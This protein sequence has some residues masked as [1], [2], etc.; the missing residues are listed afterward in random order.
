M[1][2]LISADK[3]LALT[4]DIPEWK[5]A[6]WDDYLVYRDGPSEEKVKLFFNR[7]YLF[8]EMGGEGITHASISRLFAMLFFI[9]FTRFPDKI[10]SDLGGCLLEKPEKQ[11]A[12]PDIVLYIGENIPHWKEGEPRRIDL[13]KWRVPDLVGEVADTTLASDLD[14]KKRLYADLEIPEYWV[15]DVLGKRIFA[16]R[17]Q[18]DGKYAECV[19]SAALEGLQISLLEQ[20]MGCLNEGTNVSAANWFGEAILNK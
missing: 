4:M 20:T 18:A 7:N 19:E 16:F 11:A 15:I 5:S 17:L 2:A 14:E 6:T 3:K 13:T 9:W 12:S 8:I 10:A 1:T